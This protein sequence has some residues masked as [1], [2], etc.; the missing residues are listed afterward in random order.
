MSK[1]WLR[2]VQAAVQLVLETRPQGGSAAGDSSREEVIDRLCEDLLS[3]VS[4]I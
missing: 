1:L 3:K 2:Q 4:R